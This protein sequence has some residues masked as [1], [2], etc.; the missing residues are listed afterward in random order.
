MQ[1]MLLK[2]DL[3]CGFCKASVAFSQNCDKLV[4]IRGYNKIKVILSHNCVLTFH[5]SDAL[6]LKLRKSLN[7]ISE[8]LNLRSKVQTVIAIARTKSEL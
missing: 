7:I 6:S 4:S 3:F 2:G 1:L 8:S 5:R